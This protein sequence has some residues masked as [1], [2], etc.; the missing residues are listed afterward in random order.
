MLRFALPSRGELVVSKP[1]L[2]F[3]NELAATDI[4][5][6]GL[7]AYERSVPAAR[8]MPRVREELGESGGGSQSHAKNEKKYPNGVFFSTL[9]SR[10][11]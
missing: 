7:A 5:A 3:V 10:S 4:A 1:K 6:L 8:E 2:D 11:F 9:I